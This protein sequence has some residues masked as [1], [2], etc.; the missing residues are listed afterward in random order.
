MKTGKIIMWVLGA[1]AVYA[2]WNWIKNN[3]G[4]SSDLGS[5]EIYPAPYAAPLVGPSGLMGWSPYWYYGGGGYGRGRGRGPQPG[6]RQG[7]RN[8]WPGQNQGRPQPL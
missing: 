5:S 3:T 2:A 1:I 4:G 6:P 8:L 7:R